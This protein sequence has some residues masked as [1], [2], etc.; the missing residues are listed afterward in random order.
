MTF[1]ERLKDRFELWLLKR[2]IAR[3]IHE[4]QITFLYETVRAAYK[5]EC[6][7]IGE[8]GVNENLKRCFEKSQWSRSV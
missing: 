6:Y 1:F 8:L 2:S 3:Q 7:E 4:G 5:A